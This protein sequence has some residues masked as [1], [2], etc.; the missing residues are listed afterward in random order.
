METELGVI[1]SN[2]R[3]LSHL[4]M[5]ESPAISLGEQKQTVG[6]IDPP[7]LHEDV[8]N[9]L[10]NTSRV[11][12]LV[13]VYEG[14]NRFADLVEATGQR[15]GHLLYHL[16]MLVDHGFVSQFATKEYVLTKKGLKTLVVLAQL[17]GELS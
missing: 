6:K 14:R 2:K 10:S 8:L 12:I 5:L 4:Q 3:M 13:S 11:Q 17:S 7:S 16:R 1:E 15:G 9:P